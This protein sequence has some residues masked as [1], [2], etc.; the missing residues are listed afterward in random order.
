MNRQLK[1]IAAFAVA[2][3]SLGG[4]ADQQKHGTFDQTDLK[5]NLEWAKAEQDYRFLVFASRRLVIPGFEDGDAKS[6]KQ[7]CGIRYWKN[8]GDVLYSKAERESRSAKYQFA[9]K[10]NHAVYA[11][12]NQS[13]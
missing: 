12:C 13:N 11:L 5:S 3:S 8:E 6:L 4:C 1:R 9:S 2:I 10:Y 7:Q